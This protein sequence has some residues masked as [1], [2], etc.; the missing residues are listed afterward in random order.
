MR[1]VLC[2][3]EAPP[4]VWYIIGSSLVQGEVHSYVASSLDDGKIHSKMLIF[5]PCVR[6]VY[7][8]SC[9]NEESQHECTLKAVPPRQDIKATRLKEAAMLAGVSELQG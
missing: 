2:E 9:A 1:I 8:P 5:F 3:N 4:D 7:G 6:R